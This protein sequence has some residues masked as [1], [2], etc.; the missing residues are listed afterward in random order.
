[1]RNNAGT[2]CAPLSQYVPAEGTGQTQKPNAPISLNQ[3]DCATQAPLTP[4]REWEGPRWLTAAPF[5]IVQWRSSGLVGFLR[6][7]GRILPS[8][9]NSQT[10][11]RLYV[12]FLLAANDSYGLVFAVTHTNRYGCGRQPGART[13]GGGGVSGAL[14]TGGH[15]CTQSQGTSYMHVKR[16]SSD[17]GRYT[18]T[19]SL[20]FDGPQRSQKKPP[21]AGK[22]VPILRPLW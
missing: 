6:Y 2:C 20:P 13:T 1:M 10:E 19:L 18:S 7:D 5:Y 21:A 16:I 3:S 11:N 12:R 9:P 14:T 15:R 8:I 4:S 17:V 22:K